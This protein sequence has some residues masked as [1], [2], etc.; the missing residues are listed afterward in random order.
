MKTMIITLLTVMSMMTVNVQAQNDSDVI[1]SLKEFSIFN[2]CFAD[3]D[4]NGDQVVDAAEAAAATKLSL[5][6]GGRSNIISDYSFLKHFPNLEAF[7]VGTTSLEIIDMHYLT[8]L[9]VVNVVNAPWL[10]TIIVGGDKAPEITGQSPDNKPIGV[11]FYKE[12]P[13][14]REL[15]K[16]GY[17][18]VE[19]INQDGETY[20]IVGKEEGAF[21]LWHNGK[22]EVPCQYSIDTIKQNYI[23]KGQI[24]EITDGNLTFVDQG[25]KDFCLRTKE[26]NTNNDEEITVEEAKAATHLSLMVFK[27][28]IRNIKSYEDLKY[29]PNLTYFHA[30]LTYLETLDVSCCP[31]L[32]ELDATDC[33]MLKTIVLAKGC[34]PEIKFPVAYKGVKAKVTYK[35]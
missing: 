13:E 1:I 31:N 21:G 26:I 23:T 5:E 17:S 19:P 22:L 29:F 14:A 12:A 15:F 2:N 30:G 27:S 33:R 9:K 11:I 7:S 6:R 10:K 34:K 18:Y 16:D 35:E 4:T 32:K 3:L 8:K 20:Y 24:V 28:F 25:I